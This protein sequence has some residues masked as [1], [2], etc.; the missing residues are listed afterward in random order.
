MAL[1][2]LLQVDKLTV[3]GD[4]QQLLIDNLSFSL[5][6]G[7]VVGVLGPN[8]AGK[9]SLL[10]CLFGAQRQYEGVIRIGGRDVTTLRDRQRARLVAAVTQEMPADF[11]LSVRSVIATGRTPHQHWFNGRDAA[12][13]QVISDTVRQFKLERFLDMDIN[14]LSGGERKRVMIARALVQQPQLLVLDEPCN[15]LDIEH[16]LSLMQQ[17]RELPMGCLVSLHDF[18]MAARYCDRVL[19]MCNGQLISCGPPSQ[20][21]TAQLFAS[22]FN[23]TATP[24]QNPWAQWSFYPSVAPSSN[25]AATAHNRLGFTEVKAQAQVHNRACVEPAP[26]RTQQSNYH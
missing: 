11:Q 21:L 15:H 4:A 13:E 1:Q 10:R 14:E 3:R 9:T 18:P 23:V 17:L 19:V 25:L 12:A 5:N 7:E 24:Y 2:P 8:G 22:V 20:V 16:Q 26:A 6:S